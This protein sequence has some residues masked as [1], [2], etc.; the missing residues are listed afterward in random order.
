VPHTRPHLANEPAAI[1]PTTLSFRF[2]GHLDLG[3]DEGQRQEVEARD[4]RECDAQLKQV[5]RH[6]DLQ[7]LDGEHADGRDKHL[8]AAVVVGA[9]ACNR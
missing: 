6:V 2:D 3:V 5:H 9:P 7:K 1:T 4:A 8:G